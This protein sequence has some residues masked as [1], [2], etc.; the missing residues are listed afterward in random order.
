MINLFSL[1]A[2]PRAMCQSKDH[3]ASFSRRNTFRNRDCEMLDPLKVP[4]EQ[5]LLVILDQGTRSFVPAFYLNEGSVTM[6]REHVK[7]VADKAK[8]G[9]KEN[10]WQGCG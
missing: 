9:I 6:D 7:G 1:D 2:A 8:G 10:R 5:L 3:L 4:P